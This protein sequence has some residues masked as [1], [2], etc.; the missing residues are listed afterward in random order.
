MALTKIRDYINNYGSKYGYTNDDIGWNQDSG[1]VMLGGEALVTPDYLE[2][3]ANGSSYMNDSSVL[4]TAIDNLATSQGKANTFE[5]Q[6]IEAMTYVSPYADTIDSLLDGILNKDS[7]SYDPDD[8]PMYQ[9]YKTQYENAGNTAMTNTMATAASMTGG[10]PS[11]YAVSAGNAS[12]NNYMD[13]LTDTIPELYEAAYG[14]YQDDLTNDYNALSTLASLDDTNYSRERDT[15]TDNYNITNDENNWLYQLAQDNEE[16]SRYTNETTAA[17]NQLALENERADTEWNYGLERDALDDERYEEE[18]TY[19]RNQD[20]IRNYYSSLSSSN[21]TSDDDYSDAEVMSNANKIISSLTRESVMDQG[22]TRE[23]YQ[24]EGME[25]IDELARNKANLIAE[26]GEDAYN[27]ATQ[28][29]QEGMQEGTEETEAEPEPVDRAEAYNVLT[30]K[31]DEMKTPEQVLNY[32]DLYDDT[33]KDEIGES[34]YA[35]LVEKYEI[36]IDG[37]NNNT[38]TFEDMFTK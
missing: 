36:I 10:M 31:L 32:L 6:T 23:T 13:A 5:P 25:A 20:A 30:E 22:L 19:D 29:F 8:D 28:Y 16:T 12:Y 38:S 1:Q 7:F 18:L 37:K 9:S 35:R 33:L 27:A 2:S 34:A 14:M 24:L 11:S 4:Q 3:G 21:S 15:Y 26:Y 17:A